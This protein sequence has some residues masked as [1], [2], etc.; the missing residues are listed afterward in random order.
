MKS[1]FLS[2]FLFLSLIPLGV[3]KEKLLYE[4]ANLAG[5]SLQ[6]VSRAGT[7]PNDK[8]DTFCFDG[9]NIIFLKKR[10]ESVTLF[11]GEKVKVV[12]MELDRP[13]P[14]FE[15]MDETAKFAINFIR[16]VFSDQD[17]EYC[18]DI[19]KSSKG[20]TFNEITKGTPGA[21]PKS[22]K[23]GEK[24]VVASVHT[25]P[26]Y[27]KGN[28]YKGDLG[29]S[30][31]IPSIGDYAVAS[32]Y[33][34]PQYMGAPGGHILKFDKNDIQCRGN[35]F[36]KFDYKIVQAPRSKIG[37]SLIRGDSWMTIPTG[38]DARLLKKFI[39]K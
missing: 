23:S 25:H 24:S 15:T 12:V 18:L 37:G 4:S 6:E 21:C 22:K 7:S 8:A 3:G 13:Y 38:E 29:S 9:I 32:Y 39:C 19:V 1:I 20:Y 11:S 26:G 34:T 16:D 35:S 17:V 5:K 33:N 30:I 31:Q 36:Y 10:T 28:N 27:I 14:F 2:C